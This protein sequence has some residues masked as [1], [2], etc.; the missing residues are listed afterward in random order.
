M[1]I[2][3]FFRKLK[4]VCH[5]A[6]PFKDYEWPNVLGVKFSSFSESDDTFP[7]LQALSNLYYLFVRFIDYLWSRELDISNFGLAYRKIIPMSLKPPKNGNQL[8][9]L[10]Q[11]VPSGRTL[12]VLSIPR[13]F[14]TNA[15][16]QSGLIRS[17]WLKASATT[18]AFLGCEYYGSLFEVLCGIVLFMRLEL[19]GLISTDISKITRKPS[20][21]GKHGHEKRKSTREP[22]IQSQSQRKSTSVNYGSTEV[23]SLEDKSQMLPK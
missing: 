22:K 14:M 11:R 18:F 16:T 7:S 2:T 23:N 1:D 8:R 19:L 13:R 12:N 15:L 21:T 3:E 17:F 9:F 20:K 6:D 5:W 10:I 4:Y